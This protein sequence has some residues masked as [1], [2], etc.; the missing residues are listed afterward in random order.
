MAVYKLVTGWLQISVSVL[1]LVS[2]VNNIG[3]YA[4]LCEI[5]SD[6]HPSKKYFLQNYFKYKNTELYFRPRGDG[7]EDVP[8]PTGVESAEGLCP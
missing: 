1:R 7:G 6:K 8:L 3:Q 2:V 5:L 4:V